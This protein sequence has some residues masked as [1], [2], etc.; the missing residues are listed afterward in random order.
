MLFCYGPV[1]NQQSSLGIQQSM[2][3]PKDD[4]N[5]PRRATQRKVKW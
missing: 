5:M 3:K 1:L 4:A 2:P